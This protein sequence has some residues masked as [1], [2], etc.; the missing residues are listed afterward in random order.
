MLVF[1]GIK[2]EFSVPFALREKL[3]FWK[4]NFTKNDFLNVKNR[5][6][7]S[8]IKNRKK[9]KLQVWSIE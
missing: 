2:K 6:S 3:F 8:E 5:L 9:I 7:S 4:S 1:D